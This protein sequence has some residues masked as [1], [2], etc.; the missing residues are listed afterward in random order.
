MKNK[1]EYFEQLAHDWDREHHGAEEIE[2]TRR[3]ARTF[4]RLHEGEIVLDAGCGTG[5]LIPHLRERIRDSGRVVELDLSIE[6]L[7]IGKNR[8]QDQRIL[9]IQGDGQNIP[10]K[11]RSIDTVVCF[12]FFPNL[13]DKKKAL[14]SFARVLKPGGRIIIAHQMNREELNRF[15]ANADGPVRDDILP[16]H[17]QMKMLLEEAGFANVRI[18]EKSGLY[19]ARAKAK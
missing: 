12:A 19:L 18:R 8:Y 17:G 9:F 10:L 16:D 15:H 7:R 5:R 14:T 2:K 1:R 11:D 13:A 6:M 3:F 4:F